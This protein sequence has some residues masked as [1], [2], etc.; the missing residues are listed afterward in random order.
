MRTIVA[1]ICLVAAGAIFMLYTKPTYDTVQSQNAQ[2]AQYDQ[3]LE[4]A[5]ELQQLKQSLLSRYNTFNPSDIDRLQKLLPDHVDNV[6]L[7]LDLDS[8]AGKHGMALQNVAVSG[9]ESGAASSKTASGAVGASKQKY[10]SLTIKFTTQGTYDTFR[11]FMADLEKDLRIVDL[12]SLDLSNAISSGQST[13]YT[14]DI[15]LRTYWLK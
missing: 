3:A 13:F 14:Y 10:D 12:V 11:N 6:R 7:I 9:A 5:T 2:I 1:L 4:K 8:L 15:T